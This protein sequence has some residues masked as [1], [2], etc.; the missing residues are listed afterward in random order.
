MTERICSKCGESKPETEEFFRRRG[1]KDRGGLRPDCRDCSIARDRAYYE[2]NLE[3]ERARRAAY[4]ARTR[5][6][7]KVRDQ[8]YAQTPAGKATRKRAV[9]KY[10]RTEGGRLVD[11]QRRQRR[12]AALASVGA[13]LTKPQWR[14]IVRWF[15]RECAYCGATGRLT[16]DHVVPLHRGGLHTLRNVVPACPSCNSRKHTADMETWYRAQDFFDGNRLIWIL[17]HTAGSS[18]QAAA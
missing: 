15:G 10:R 3:R 1:T 14:K 5:E 8:A 4:R 18:A 13:D 6:Q 17:V 16:Q 9:Q 2:A 12:R 7:A 11:I